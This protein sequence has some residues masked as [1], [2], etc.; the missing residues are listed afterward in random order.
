MEQAPDPRNV[1]A[2]FPPSPVCISLSLSLSLFSLSLSLSLVNG[3]CEPCIRQPHRKGSV[4]NV[5]PTNIRPQSDAPEIRKYKKKFNA[6]ISVPVCGV[7]HAHISSL[8]SPLILIKTS[9]K[10]QEIKVIRNYL[11]TSQ[12]LHLLNKE[13]LMH[14]VFD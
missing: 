1:L 8:R 2:T 6:E 7:R 11:N 5:N 12:L 13:A 4:V 10:T 3:R 9:C 14:T